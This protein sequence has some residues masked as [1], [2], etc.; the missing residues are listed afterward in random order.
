M[1]EITQARH[2][3]EILINRPRQRNAIN[4]AMY[5]E[6]DAALRAAQADTACRSVIIS[7]AAGHF[8]AGNDLK[9][10]QVPRGDQDS[11]GLA[12]LRTLATLD[13]PVIAAVEGQAV[14]IGVTLLQ[15]CDFVYAGASARFS[16]PFVALGLCP[17]GGSSL[18]MAQIAGARKAAQWLLAGRPFDAREACEA[19]LATALL[20][21]GQALAGARAQAAALADLPAEALRLTKRM[22]GQAQRQA[23]MQA[24]DAERD[25]FRQRLQSDEAQAAFRRFFERKKN[26]PG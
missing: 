16:M 5:A 15:H 9:E 4:N 10:F 7:G 17:E 2:C 26:H 1:I 6:L 14:G 22:L 11:P 12:F 3:V 20:P 8:T 13:V 18:L 24:F 25:N 21:A 19:G 23:L